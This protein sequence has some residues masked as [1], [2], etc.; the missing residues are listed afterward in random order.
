MGGG[1][2]GI[3]KEGQMPFSGCIYYVAV[4]IERFCVQC[5]LAY[6]QLG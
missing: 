5:T 1:G 3:C 4:N 6:T 2:G